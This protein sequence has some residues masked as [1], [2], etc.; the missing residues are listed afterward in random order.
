MRTIEMEAHLK[1]CPHCAQNLENQQK[2][3]AALRRSLP[4]FAA[5]AALRERIK[6]SLRASNVEIL[7]ERKTQWLSL[8]V[9]Q[10][11]GAITALV[12]FSLIGWQLNVHFHTPS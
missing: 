12:L 10:L 6:S 2:L 9:W 8:R 4:T 5:P 1:Y 7:K 11:V 3:R